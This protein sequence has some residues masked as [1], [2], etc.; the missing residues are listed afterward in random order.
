MVDVPKPEFLSRLKAFVDD[1]SNPV[2]RKDLTP[3]NEEAWCR[4]PDLTGQEFTID[5][6]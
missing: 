2:N 4:V 3:V 1:P 6:P 5:P